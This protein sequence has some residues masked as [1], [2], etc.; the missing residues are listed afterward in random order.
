MAMQRSAV[1]RVSLLL[2]PLELSV[3]SIRSPTP[4]SEASIGYLVGQAQAAK[5][6]ARR[7][8]TQP[9]TLAW[10]NGFLLQG[11]S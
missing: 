1:L 7:F 6:R 4:P 10:E 2:C 11:S 9:P 8:F 3:S 5:G